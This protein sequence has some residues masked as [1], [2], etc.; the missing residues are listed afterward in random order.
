MVSLAAGLGAAM[1]AGL[2][3]VGVL[4]RPRQSASAIDEAERRL[5]PARHEEQDV[6]FR[7]LVLGGLVVLLLVAGAAGLAAWLYPGTDKTTLLPLPQFPAP[8]LQT[9]PPADMATLHAEQLRQLTGAYWIDRERDVVH[10][11]IED[12]MRA[13]AA[14]GVADWPRTPRVQR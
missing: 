7:P 3:S 9:A 13:V 10:L 6:G 8:Q 11:P 12:A 4:V 1:A 2:L 14:T 5:P